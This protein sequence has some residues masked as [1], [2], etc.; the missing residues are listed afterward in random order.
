VLLDF[1]RE[2][3]DEIIART[4]RRVAERRVPRADHTELEKGI[5]L[6]LTQLT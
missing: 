2:S 1:L 4:R 5:P 6:F 3:R